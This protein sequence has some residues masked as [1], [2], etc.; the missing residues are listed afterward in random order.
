ML[1]T[2][3]ISILYFNTETVHEI[4]IFQRNNIT[5]EQSAFMFQTKYSKIYLNIIF[6]EIKIRI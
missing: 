2:Y 1:K 4:N 3:N 6:N 5:A